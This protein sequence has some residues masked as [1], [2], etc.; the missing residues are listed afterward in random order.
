MNEEMIKDME[1]MDTQVQENEE[2]TREE[3]VEKLDEFP[4]EENSGNGEA[5]GLLIA[6]GI[7]IGA[8]VTA[9]VGAVIRKVKEKKAERPKRRKSRKKVESDEAIDV[10]YEDLD[11]EDTEVEVPKSG[12]T[13]KAG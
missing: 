13:E 8:A 5:I 9:G 2:T 6:G 7:A 1:T 4:T 12:K 11:E 10:E 3:L